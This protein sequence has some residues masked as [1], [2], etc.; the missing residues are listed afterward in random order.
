MDG[1]KENPK[2]TIASKKMKFSIHYSFQ[3]NFQCITDVLLYVAYFKIKESNC[4]PF[5]ATYFVQ[6]MRCLP[7]E[8]AH[9]FNN[10]LENAANQI[11]PHD[12]FQGN[13]QR[14]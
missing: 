7:L 1:G 5:S 10:Q 8:T 4:E 9:D 3:S 13:Q 14:H 6:P 2:D 11:S 12:S